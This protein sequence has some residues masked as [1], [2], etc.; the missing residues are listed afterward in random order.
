M[1]CS[2]LH[3]LPWKNKGQL[4]KVK[5]EWSVG[6]TIPD[7]DLHRDRA[8]SRE[9]GTSTGVWGEE[10]GWSGAFWEKPH[11]VS[12]EVERKEEATLSVHSRGERLSLRKFNFGQNIPLFAVV[13]GC[14][15]GENFL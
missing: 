9:R 8:H 6:E 12:P 11:S 5:L 3:P 2:V 1:P 10:G 15:E 7:L 13:N 14:E 4:G